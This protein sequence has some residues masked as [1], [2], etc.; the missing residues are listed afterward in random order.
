VRDFKQNL[1]CGSRSV[2]KVQGSF[3]QISWLFLVMRIIFFLVGIGWVPFIWEGFF[4][5]FRGVE[6]GLSVLA[7]GCFLL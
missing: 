1:F 2:I 7:P 4:P 3:L 6:E 5:D